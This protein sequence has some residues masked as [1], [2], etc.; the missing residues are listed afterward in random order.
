MNLTEPIFIIP[1]SGIGKAFGTI[2]RE[3]TYHVIEDLRRGETDTLCLSLLVIGD[4]D[5]SHLVQSHRCIAIDGCPLECAKKNL[6][7]AGANLTTNFRV[8]DLLKEH[9]NLKPKSVTFLDQ[10]GR[11]LAKLLADQISAK[12][13]KLNQGDNAS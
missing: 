1:C 3:A 12:V 6:L 13:D 4:K 8:V 7:L 10:E 9:R 5:S 2:S 11:E